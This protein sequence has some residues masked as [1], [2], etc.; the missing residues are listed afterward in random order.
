MKCHRFLLLLV[1]VFAVV[2]GC[3]ADRTAPLEPAVA[4]PMGGPG[5]DAR[6]ALIGPGGGSVV[7]G[8]VRIDVPAGALSEPV[9]ISIAKLSD[10]SVDLT[11]NGQRFLAPVTLTFSLA[12]GK[13]PDRHAVEWLDPANGWVPIP[14]EV[15]QG[16]RAARLMHFSIY[17][18]IEYE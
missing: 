18:I 5:L 6:A 4:L 8:D 15:A 9:V 17:H 14:S 7:N 10:G 16:R 11:P 2:A 1:A 13:D 12:P 3:S